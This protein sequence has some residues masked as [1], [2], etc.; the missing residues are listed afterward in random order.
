MRY[1][2][3]TSLFFNSLA[4]NDKKQIEDSYR[5]LRSVKSKS[6]PLTRYM[7][8]YTSGLM[9]LQL[10]KFEDAAAKFLAAAQMADRNEVGPLY[11]CCL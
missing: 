9:D 6:T 2:L 11:E 5:K 1:K 10:E 7:E 3:C 4:L 8:V